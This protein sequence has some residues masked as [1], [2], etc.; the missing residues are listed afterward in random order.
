MI[1]DVEKEGPILFSE[2]ALTD[3]DDG[4]DYSLQPCSYAYWKSRKQGE[5][6]I[7]LG[8]TYRIKRVAI[9]V[10]VKESHGTQK[11]EL[12]PAE[13]DDPIAT[14]DPASD[15]YNKFSDLDLEVQKLRLRLHLIQGRTYL[16]IS[17]IQVWGDRAE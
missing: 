10:L 13:G 17:E 12:L 7:D 16:T 8:D 3:G 5:V 11:I 9:K 14:I 2:G 15:G 1:G 6:L 4:Y